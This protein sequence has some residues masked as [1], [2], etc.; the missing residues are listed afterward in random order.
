MK[1]ALRTLL[2]V[3]EELA[4]LAKSSVPKLRKGEVVNREWL[5]DSIYYRETTFNGKT[6]QSTFDFKRRT[7]FY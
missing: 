3:A 2:T 4:E 7:I 1:N 6:C 5:N